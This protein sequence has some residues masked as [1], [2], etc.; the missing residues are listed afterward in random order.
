MLCAY[1]SFR[2]R[3]PRQTLFRQR[4]ALV[5]YY[6]IYKY[7]SFLNLSNILHFVLPFLLFLQP[8]PLLLDRPISQQTV[9]NSHPVTLCCNVFC[10]TKKY[11]IN[12]VICFFC[13]VFFAL[14]TKSPFG[15]TL[16]W[17]PYRKKL[18]QIGH[19]SH[20]IMAQREAFYCTQCLCLTGYHSKFSVAMPNSLH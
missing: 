6:V 14:L 13:F 9:I 2:S 11:C 20:A 4:R 18:E 3:L 5:C 15:P 16:P 7:S 12:K 8:I 1:L 10:D 17:N 19:P